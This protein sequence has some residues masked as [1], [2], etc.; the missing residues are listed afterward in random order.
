MTLNTTNLGVIYYAYASTHHSQFAYQIS[1]CLTSGNPKICYGPIIL[2]QVTIM[3]IPIW[4]NFVMPMPK[5]V[6]ACVQNVKTLMSPVPT[7]PEIYKWVT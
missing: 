3:T 6:T 7:D 2:K 5:V 1:K 4:G